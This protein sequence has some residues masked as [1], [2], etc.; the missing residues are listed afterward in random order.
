MIPIT[1][2]THNYNLNRREKIKSEIQ[3]KG[4]APNWSTVVAIITFE[5]SPKGDAP[6]KSRLAFSAAL[7]VG[8]VEECSSN[9]VL[10]KSSVGN[11]LPVCEVCVC[12]FLQ[13]VGY[14]VLNKQ[15]SINY[16]QAT[17][18]NTAR[19]MGPKVSIACVWT[20]VSR[21]PSIIQPA[22]KKRHSK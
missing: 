18:Y 1:Y 5:P 10:P 13:C 9:G 17:L 7:W 8:G 2:K 22:P 11:G 21:P 6:N 20:C 15:W 19:L 14:Y 4:T 16:T 3:L 12:V